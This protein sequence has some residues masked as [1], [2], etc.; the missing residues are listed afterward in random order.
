MGE[1]IMKKILSIALAV[2]ITISSQLFIAVSANQTVDENTADLSSDETALLAFPGAEGGGKYTKGARG[3]LD[4][5]P[6][7]N[8]PTTLEVYHVTNLNS[9]GEG[10]LTDAVSRQGRLIVFDVGGV[11]DL[12]STLRIEN[13]NITILGQ[14]AP[15]DG[16]TIT[17]GDVQ[18][19]DGVSNVIIRYL[20]I[21]PTNKNGQEVDGIGGK[22][23]TDIIIDHCSTSW[24]VDEA[25]TLYA[26][27]QEKGEAG[28][29]LT[30]Q[31]TIT[32]ESMRMSGHF[33][34]AHGYGGIIG[35]TNATYYRNLFAHH[36]S[37]SPRLDRALQKTDFRNNIVYNWGVTNSA[38]GGE[39]ASRHGD[40]KTP[41]LVN[42]SNNYY[43][44][45]PSTQ[46]GKRYRIFDFKDQSYEDSDGTVYKSQ[47][48][49]TDNY[50]YGSSTVTDNNWASA[51]ANEGSEARRVNEPFSLGDDIYSDLNLTS[52]LPGAEVM[53]SILP[54]VGATLP[55]RDATDARVVADVKNQTGRIINNEEEV[56]GIIGF[57]ET[58]KTFVIPED[59]KAANGM[60]QDAGEGDIIESGE[61]A[62]YTWIEAYVNEWTDAQSAPT[63]PDITVLSPA[64]ASINSTVNGQTVNN[65]NWTVINDT[66]TLNYRANAAA[67]GDT[68][69]TKMELYDDEELIKTYD[70]AAS[71]DDSLSLD[72]GT[73]YLSCVAYNDK[74]ESTR[75]T[76]SIVYVNGSTAP[77]GW[78]QRQVGSPTFSGKGATSYD[79][80]TGIYTMG[81]SGKIGGTADKFDFMYK[82]VSGDFDISIKLENIPAN[83]NGPAFGL[84][85][86]ETL[87][88][89]SRMAALV[90][91]WLKYGRNQ[92]IVARTKKGSNI[93][94]D[95]D[96]SN[97]TDNKIGI[98]MKDSSGNIVSGNVMGESKYDTSPGGSCEPGNYLRIQRSGDKLI[99]SVSD[100]GTDWTD[101]IRQPYTMTMSG[102]ADKLYVGVTIDAHQG[103]SD[104]SPK[105]YYS[106]AQYSALTLDNQA[107]IEEPVVKPTPEPGIKYPFPVYPGWKVGQVSAD[108]TDGDAEQIEYEGKTSLHILDRNVYKTLDS[109]INSGKVI[110]STDLYLDPDD[111]N[112]FRIY[113]E[114]GNAEDYQDSSNALGGVIAEVINS[115]NGSL[116]A[117]PNLGSSAGIYNFGSAQPGWV[118]IEIGIDY[119]KDSSASDFITLTVTDAQDVELVNASMP[120][121]SGVDA[122]L[123][124]IRLVARSVE[125]YFANMSIRPYVEDEI[126][127]VSV[128]EIAD[129]AAVITLK[130]LTDSEKKVNIFT[131]QYGQEGDMLTSA[132]SVTD[133]IAAGAEKQIT[134]TGLANGAKAYIWNDNYSPYCDPVEFTE[135]AS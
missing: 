79:A 82:E 3:V 34:G 15:G 122:S 95:S 94:T 11:I 12:P 126:E 45:G 90:D 52:I 35:G 23:N 93:A 135:S 102:L 27:D 120:A 29:R 36:D 107:N 33:K 13:D 18:I 113:L 77:E 48:Y 88:A 57:E 54:T 109:A 39:A 100:S 114:N 61:N 110:F 59:W 119:S 46:T 128:G 7:S 31:N 8:D 62:G 22:Y 75:S 73:H 103:Q 47:F 21:R 99:F 92:R 1:L 30:V 97:S 67:V 26:G 64:I 56:G 91:G 51:G 108:A 70:G 106:M 78:T 43:K 38:Y 69:V 105:G 81:G 116:C 104:A 72:M 55:K 76:T 117:G 101:N 50:V 68:S 127:V 134:L 40:I 41:S 10:S 124:Q 9:E 66:Q 20:R 25:L 42:Y 32:S 58:H 130:N 24:C 131:A 133:T 86:R 65:G 129:G 2:I 17:G 28:H 84:M 74:G 112:G 125:P 80:E 63:N 37:R 121:I 4:N 132:G 6:N 60:P 83:E 16:I 71:I 96:N 44:Y 89:N 115:S 118:N 85:V 49:M 19:A 14:T 111:K 87:D 123:K 98:F 53:D 5:D